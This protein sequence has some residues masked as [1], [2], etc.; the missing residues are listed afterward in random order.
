MRLCKRAKN[1]T[2]FTIVRSLVRIS[3][4]YQI[5]TILVHFKLLQPL[6]KLG[7]INKLNSVFN[8]DLPL[9]VCLLLQLIYKLGTM[10]FRC[11]LT[12]IVHLHHNHW[13]VTDL[14]AFHI[15]KHQR[16]TNRHFDY[17]FRP[18]KSDNE[19]YFN[20]MLLFIRPQWNTYLYYFRRH[21]IRCTTEAISRFI[22]IDL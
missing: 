14:L 16:T 20:T 15:I 12:K 6:N 2:I 18:T 9:L 13:M 1:M 3:S 10:E 8:S 7:F 22:Q 5:Y 4:F 17:S 21:I 19:S 11:I